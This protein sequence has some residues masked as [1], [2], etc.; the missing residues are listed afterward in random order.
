MKHVNGAE[1]PTSTCNVLWIAVV[2]IFLVVATAAAAFSANTGNWFGMGSDNVMGIADDVM[3][4]N[5]MGPQPRPYPT[6]APT[7][8]CNPAAN[9]T[10][11]QAGA[12][13]RKFTYVSTKNGC[14]YTITRDGK[15][16]ATVTYD[17]STAT[18]KLTDPN[19]SGR[20]ILQLGIPPGQ[21]PRFKSGPVIR[22]EQVIKLTPR[23]GATP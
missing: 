3:P 22:T 23:P 19:G 11:T 14:V 21:F 18:Y 13:G 1:R 7:P 2:A 15:A 17:A 10:V 12:N 16:W 20:L 4:P 5:G 9:L 8:N 6:T